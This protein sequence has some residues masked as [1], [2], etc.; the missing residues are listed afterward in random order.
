MTFDTK[1]WSFD[2]GRGGY[3]FI[4]PKSLQVTKIVEGEKTDMES[5]PVTPELPNEKQTGLYPRHELS[6]Q[7]ISSP[8]IRFDRSNFRNR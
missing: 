2:R 6:R 8:A 4:L 7:T 3:Y 1:N 5:L